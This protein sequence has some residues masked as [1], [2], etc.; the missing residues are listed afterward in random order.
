H[1]GRA[2]AVE[3][4][5]DADGRSFGRSARRDG[6]GRLGA[7]P[8]TLESSDGAAR[9]RHLPRPGQ[10]D[11]RVRVTAR[12]AGYDQRKYE[13]ELRKSKHD[14]SPGWLMAP[15]TNQRDRKQGENTCRRYSG[16]YFVHVSSESFHP[17]SD[18]SGPPMQQAG[19]QWSVQDD[20]QVPLVDRSRLFGGRGYG[21][22]LPAGRTGDCRQ[23]PAAANVSRGGRSRGRRRS[24]RRQ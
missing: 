11:G 17:R 13:N 5:V 1:V 4:A 6:R 19:G 15:P 12:S 18:V 7:G 16:C 2:V 24:G 20:G 22:R 14:Q 21:N 9:R 8:E 23:L 3:V 10:D